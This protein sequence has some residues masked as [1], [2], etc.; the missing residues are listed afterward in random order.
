S[1]SAVSAEDYSD[2]PSP[3]PRT[4][5]AR[6][7][8]MHPSPGSSSS[9]PS[10]AVST[11]SFV[12]S[13]LNPSMAPPPTSQ[14]PFSTPSPSARSRPA[15]RASHLEFASSHLRDRDTTLAP[16]TSYPSGTGLGMAGLAGQRGSM[17][18]YRLASDDDAP[19]PPASS[20]V[21]SRDSAHLLPPP[22]LRTTPRTGTVPRLASALRH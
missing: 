14:N 2:P 5:D 7:L 3:S 21:Y 19:T 22:K 13:P 10:R 18:L 17:L 12:S 16:P 8:P 9:R 1:M 20:S 11:A 4:E 15:S 6:L